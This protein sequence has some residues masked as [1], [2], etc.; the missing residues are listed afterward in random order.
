MHCNGR[1][2]QSSQSPAVMA[3]PPSLSIYV[4]IY[5]GRCPPATSLGMGDPSRP[6]LGS[7]RFPDCEIDYIINQDFH[8]FTFI[9]YIFTLMH[10]LN[11]FFIF[12]ILGYTYNL[13]LFKTMH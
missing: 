9:I 1:Q 2:P 6:V 12:I 8:I 3:D 10:R 5:S 11:Y 13:C 4:D 7:P